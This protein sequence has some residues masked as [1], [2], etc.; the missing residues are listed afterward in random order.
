LLKAQSAAPEGGRP[1]RPLHLAPPRAATEWKKNED[2]GKWK[3]VWLRPW[4]LARIPAFLTNQCRLGTG[5]LT[6]GTHTWSYTYLTTHRCFIPASDEQVRLITKWRQ[7]SR[8]EFFALPSNA[9][10]I[11]HH[12]GS[13]LCT[14]L[15]SCRPTY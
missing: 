9:T 15:S 3:N 8:A 12:V 7:Y 13:Y 2:K 11:H 4:L 1:V 5:A 6:P 14:L 10:K